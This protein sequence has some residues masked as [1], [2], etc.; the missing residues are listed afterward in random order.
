MGLNVS[1]IFLL[2]VRQ[3][4][5]ETSATNR[6]RRRYFTRQLPNHPPPQRLPTALLGCI[7]AEIL[8]H[9]FPGG[10]WKGGAFRLS[11]AAVVEVHLQRHPALLRVPGTTG[12]VAV[13]MEQGARRH[14]HVYQRLHPPAE[15]VRGRGQATSWKVHKQKRA[16]QPIASSI[17][18]PYI[19]VATSKVRTSRI[20]RLYV[21]VCRL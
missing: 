14:L 4:D 16:N 7:N 5:I 11:L 15:G 1:Q 17:V 12:D 20:E 8:S 13:L 2:D 19:S 9:I 3:T 10:V 6:A 18:F 21:E